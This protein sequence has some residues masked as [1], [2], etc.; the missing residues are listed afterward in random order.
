MTSSRLST[1]SGSAAA[2]LRWRLATRSSVTWERRV[3]RARRCCWAGLGG[4]VGAGRR[5][6]PKRAI[7][8]ASMRS[9]FSRAPIASA[10]RR[11]LR[12]DEAAGQAGLPEQ[13]EG[14]PLVAAA[15]LHHDEP[16]A[17]GS[18]EGAERGDA[19]R[20]VAKPLRG[21]ARL[22]MGGEPILGDIHSTD[23]GVHGNLPCACD[24]W[25]PSDCSVVRDR[26]E[27]PG[28]PTVGAGGVSGDF[29]RH[30]AGYRI[31]REAPLR[32]LRPKSPLSRS[33]GGRLRKRRP[34]GA[35]APRS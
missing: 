18:A 4:G 2:L 3:T 25:R 12:V 17:L 8:A 30:R 9:V 23:D 15:R 5:A 11:T 26:A 31:R 10:K 34:S 22:E 7:M 29:A 16:G 35:A 27:I 14:E 28:S 21:P 33:E 6:C 1:A 19:G 24:W 32:F 13:E 20:V